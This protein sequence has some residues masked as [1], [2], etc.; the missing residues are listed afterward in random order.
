MVVEILKFMFML[1]KKRGGRSRI[2]CIYLYWFLK[3][4]VFLEYLVDFIYLYF[5][6]KIMLYGYLYGM[7][8]WRC[9]CKEEG[10]N[11][12]WVDS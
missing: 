3:V 9:V 10:V 5:K 7:R 8:G 4:S 11:E 2:R 12:Y 1:G 6:G